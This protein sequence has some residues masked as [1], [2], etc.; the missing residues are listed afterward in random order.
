MI[1]TDM[2][3]NQVEQTLEATKGQDEA[4]SLTV[5]ELHRQLQGYGFTA[6]KSDCKELL[7]ELV[8]EQ[9]LRRVKDGEG[10]VLRE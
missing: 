3:K 7:E 4:E 6:S 1:N 2:L 9:V 10:Y 8:E 5:D